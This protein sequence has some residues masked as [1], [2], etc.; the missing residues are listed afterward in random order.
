MYA[1]VL[2]IL[3]CYDGRDVHISNVYGG[4]E[5]LFFPTEDNKQYPILLWN[6]EFSLFYHKTQSP[7]SC[8][9]RICQSQMLGYR[10]TF[11]LWSLI[12]LFMGVPLLLQVP[13]LSKNIVYFIH[14]WQPPQA[15]KWQT[16]ISVHAGNCKRSGNLTTL[17][18]SGRER[19]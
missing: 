15:I 1:A 16:G 9:H 14:L 8:Y 10:V 2:Y 18:S 19:E 6:C 5:V 3:S 13:H 11:H 4:I 17:E 7:F 12:L